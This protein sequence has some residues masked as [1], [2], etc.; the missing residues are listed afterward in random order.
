MKSKRSDTSE[1]EE[2]KEIPR[3]NSSGRTRDASTFQS[4]EV[5]N[6]AKKIKIFN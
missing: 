2:E 4:I 6:W 3:M 5:R 1:S